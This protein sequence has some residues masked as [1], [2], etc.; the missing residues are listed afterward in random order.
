MVV[1]R[2]GGIRVPA[3]SGS[4]IWHTLRMNYSVSGYSYKVITQLA[5][6]EEDTELFYRSRDEQGQLLQQVCYFSN[7][8]PL[9]TFPF[10]AVLRLSRIIV[11]Y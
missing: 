1:S 5:G 11:S 7:A 4:L 10:H 9:N 3:S 6:L 2:N 8:V